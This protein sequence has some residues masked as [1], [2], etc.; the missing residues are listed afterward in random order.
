MHG[1]ETRPL[2]HLYFTSAAKL[3]PHKSYM[4]LI[5]IPTTPPCYNNKQAWRTNMTKLQHVHER[6]GYIVFVWERQYVV[7]SSVNR[8]YSH[9]WRLNH[10]Y[11]SPRFTDKMWPLY[12]PQWPLMHTKLESDRWATK[13]QPQ[14]LHESYV[15]LICIRKPSTLLRVHPLLLTAYLVTPLHIPGDCLSHMYM[16]IHMYMHMHHS[17]A[18]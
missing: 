8:T 1:R 13:S 6:H 2:K 3:R 12:P 4:A 18:H 9:S 5:S 17:G 16:H 14:S 15:D 10:P 7:V 11:Y